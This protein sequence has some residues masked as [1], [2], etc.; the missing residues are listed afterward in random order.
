MSQ[1]LANVLSDTASDAQ[2]RS[3]QLADEGRAILRLATPIMLIALLNLG[4]SVTDT[5][6]VSALFGADALAAV[7]V[8]SDLY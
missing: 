4:M 6:M 7:A 1:A 2:S 5:I 3:R 8:G